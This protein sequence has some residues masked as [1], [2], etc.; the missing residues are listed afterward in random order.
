MVARAYA[1]KIAIA[2][3]ADFFS[4]KFIVD[5]LK[6]SLDASLAK[7]GAKVVAPKH[8]Q[9]FNDRK[10]GF[11]PRKGGGPQRGG[12]PGGFKGNRRPGPRDGGGGNQ[13]QPA[14]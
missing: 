3:K 12:R 5:R 11:K 10:G 1:T 7:I 4:K 6:E 8:Y 14:W 2:V 13:P 9:T